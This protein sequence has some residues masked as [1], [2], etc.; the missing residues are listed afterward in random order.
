MRTHTFQLAKLSKVLSVL[1]FF[2]IIFSFK[3]KAQVF[4]S[5]LNIYEEK[6][7]HEKIHI[8]FDRTMYNTGETIFYKLYILSGEEWTSLSK[9]VYVS[10]Y[11][12][13]G[14][15]IKQTVAPLFQSSAKGSFEVPADYKG[16][17]LR[18][19]AY[20][21]WMLNDDSVFLYEKY[22]SI[23]NGVAPKTK[24]STT[25]KTRVDVF[26]E[27]GTFVQGLMHTI[28]FKATNNFG[29]PVFIKGFLVNDKNKV[30]YTLKVLHDG[31]GAF[32]L[33]PLEG[34]K[35]QLNWTDENGVKGTSPIVAASKEGVI[36]KI[37]MDNENA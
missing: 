26:P 13:N 1:F 2:T 16:N 34:E 35:Y 24:N 6:F 36:L 9:N 15:F 28:A 33:R 29:S 23:N 10:W 30:L 20:T 17:F 18:A 22:I 19:K 37:S 5:L 3:S 11:D 27:G 14:N 12:N 8:H 25:P 31:M 32:K 21:R 7:P 4:D